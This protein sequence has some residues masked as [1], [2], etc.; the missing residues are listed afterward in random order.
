M[1]ISTTY[2]SIYVSIFKLLAQ[3]VYVMFY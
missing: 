3:V 1:L 2:V